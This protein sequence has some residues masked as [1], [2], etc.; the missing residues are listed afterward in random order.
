M[1]ILEYLARSRPLSTNTALKG[2]TPYTLSSLSTR[3]AGQVK[4]GRLWLQV[5]KEELVGGL[6]SAFF[7]AVLSAD[8]VVYSTY[9]AGDGHALQPKQ[10]SQATTPTTATREKPANT[11]DY[12]V[13]SPGYRLGG[14]EGVAASTDPEKVGSPGAPQALPPQS[15]RSPNTMDEIERQKRL[16][17]IE[18]RA[19]GIL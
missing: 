17:A 4:D 15:P 2:A 9:S 8:D 11:N 1:H 13:N 12:A 6:I 10:Q 3:Q 18:K 16:D 19:V 5:R 14:N 7:T